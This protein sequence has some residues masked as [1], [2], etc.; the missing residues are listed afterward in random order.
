MPT[1]VIITIS[2]LPAS[3]DAGWLYLQGRRA[4]TVI[5][6]EG[7][8]AVPFKLYLASHEAFTSNSHGRRSIRFRLA[9][10]H[11]GCSIA[12][13][14]AHVRCPIANRTREEYPRSPGGG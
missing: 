11:R 10:G 4:I 8:V 14:K 5:H 3:A 7:R 12:M 9:V 13:D 6:S 1:V 2:V